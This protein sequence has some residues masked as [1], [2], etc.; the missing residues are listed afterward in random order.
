[1]GLWATDNASA[2]GRP[3]YYCSS[4]AFKMQDENEGKAHLA[5]QKS[6]AKGSEGVSVDVAKEGSYKSSDNK[7]L[8]VVRIKPMGV[9]GG[10]VEKSAAGLGSVEVS[11]AI[12]LSASGIG[13]DGKQFSYPSCVITPDMDQQA[14]FDEFMPQR[15]D[16]FFS[17]YNVNVMAYGQTGSGKTHT[18]FGPPGIMGRAGAGEYGVGLCQ[19]Y[20]LFP[21]CLLE[22]FACPRAQE[23]RHSGQFLRADRECRGA[24]YAGERGHAGEG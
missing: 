20:G 23:Y 12:E 7:G 14:L 13:V 22:I 3:T 17:G 9:G 19:G 1:V 10:G 18:M 2:V 24:E 5:S 6:E 4:V 21:R 8:G 16:G 11:S 15:I